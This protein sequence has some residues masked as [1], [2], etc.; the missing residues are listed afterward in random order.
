MPSFRNTTSLRI[1]SKI[2]RMSK[3]RIEMHIIEIIFCFKKYFCN[4]V[5]SP[6][7]N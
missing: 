1:I 4:I 3:Y 2:T 7:F 5:K 6:Y